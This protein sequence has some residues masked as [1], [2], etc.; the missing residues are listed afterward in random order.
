MSILNKK[1]NMKKFFYLI[2]CI[3]FVF[4]IETHAQTGPY[5]R[6]K[7]QANDLQ[8][9]ALLIGGIDFEN[10]Q[11][12]GN[13]YT[14]EL[15]KEEYQVLQSICKN[16]EVLIN[17]L[18]KY[19]ANRSV[20]D[21]KSM[22]K[23]NTQNSAPIGFSLGSLAGFQ[24]YQEMTA[25]IDSMHSLYPN[26]T[27]QKVSIGKTLEN[28]DIWMI[29][30]SDNPDVDELDEAEV[31]YDAMHHARE[32]Q[33]MMQMLYFMWDLLEKY[34]NGDS[35]AKYIVENRELYFIPII[36]VDGYVYNQNVS[37]SGG[38]MWRKNRKLNADNTIGVDLNRNYSK[39]W[40][41]DDVGSSPD[42]FSNTFRGDSAFSEPETRVLRSFVNS[43][44]FVSNLSYHSYGGYL[45]Y[46]YGAQENYY[47]PDST[48]FRSY[49]DRLT[50]DNL[51]SSG[52]VFETLNYFANGGSC[53][54]MYA[55]QN[56]H[57]KIISFTPEVGDGF[58]GFWPSP[59]RIIPLAEENLSANIFLALKCV[60]E[61]KPEVAQVWMTVNSDFTLPV[62]FISNGY[63]ENFTLKTYLEIL[64][65]KNAVVSNTDTIKAN[66]LN[67]FSEFTS[68]IV[69]QINSADS[70]EI[71]CRLVT[72]VDGQL[73]Y[74]TIV[75]YYIDQ[76]IGI[77]QN[78]MKDLNLYPNPAN[79][80]LYLK[81]A[82]FNYCEYELID[83]Q[84]RIL[85][86][87]ELNVNDG[88][89]INHLN[90]G[91]YLLHIVHNNQHAYKKFTV[92]K[93]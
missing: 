71:L 67:T 32:P 52:T 37:P 69:I 59:S 28:R 9:K 1:T 26:I 33:A 47:T 11:K 46:P 81:N 38:G 55:A 86:R 87:D 76:A 73:R 6:V 89:S 65:N 17:D 42:G 78:T 31:L 64:S 80:V 23:V 53:D 30:I 4:T 19:Y 70:A 48:L 13:N 12:N 10:V 8:K 63:A 36:N 58:D 60:N 75:I 34:Q 85:E 41:F 93:N 50:V 43:R 20:N 18:E 57:D 68:N 40:G 44:H 35:V 92:L 56:E 24:N 45:I 84:G 77:E 27:T 2:C 21:L 91:T 14:A 3:S 88:I 49:A 15:S 39:D 62:R 74:D 61:L 72:E 66:Q 90:E 25:S 16:T 83:L 79:K 51:Y 82:D 7:F 22:K 5:K 54:W 29:K